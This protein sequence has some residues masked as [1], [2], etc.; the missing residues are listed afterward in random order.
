MEKQVK[1]S[2]GN[3]HKGH[4]I[5]VVTNW[6]HTQEPNLVFKRLMKLLLKPRD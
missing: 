5:K 3:S 1:N 6:Q 4:Q 2:K